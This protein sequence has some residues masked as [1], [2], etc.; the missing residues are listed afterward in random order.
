M[1][2]FQAEEGMFVVYVP[3]HAKGIQTHIDCEPGRIVRFHDDRTAF[4]KYF[5]KEQ[6]QFTSELQETAKST[7]I[8]LLWPL[9]M[10]EC[11]DCNGSGT[12]FYS[13]CGGDRVDGDMPLCPTCKEHLGEEECDTCEGTGLVKIEDQVKAGPVVDLISQA[14]TRSEGDR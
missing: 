7:S 14:E 11:P 3:Q 12:A 13:C 2:K 9:G 4:V 10:E 6:G 5:K 8:S 1:R